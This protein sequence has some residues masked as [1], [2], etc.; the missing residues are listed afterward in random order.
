MGKVQC[1]IVFLPLSIHTVYQPIVSSVFWEAL[2][3]A[4]V[5]EE[6]NPQESSYWDFEEGGLQRTEY[7]E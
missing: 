6:K 2:G 4:N 7:K 1:I 3:C 5:G